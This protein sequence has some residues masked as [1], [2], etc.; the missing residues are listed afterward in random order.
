MRSAGVTRRDVQL[1]EIYTGPTPTEI[2]VPGIGTNRNR[3]FTKDWGASNPM[4]VS[5]RGEDFWAY[6]KWI[7]Q[8]SLIVF[9][10][11]ASCVLLWSFGFSLKIRGI[12]MCSI[13]SRRWW[14]EIFV[15]SFTLTG[16]CAIFQYPTRSSASRSW[17]SIPVHRS[18]LLRWPAHEDLN[19]ARGRKL[20]NL[21]TKSHEIQF[22]F[23]EEIEEEAPTRCQAS[24]LDFHLHP[25]QSLWL[26]G[27]II[28][29]FL[30]H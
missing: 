5:D 18:K 27:C 16:A 26:L 13:D 12:Y 21:K 6:S 3:Q 9:P 29:Y 4:H 19:Y 15:T 2:E 7:G 17:F 1:F 24:N 14:I 10:S 20:P 23:C 22:D 28:I 30:L 11:P 8:R 25:T